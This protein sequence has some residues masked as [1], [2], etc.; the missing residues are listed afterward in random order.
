VTH[1]DSVD[2]LAEFAGPSW[3]EAVVEPG[4]EHMLAEVSCDHYET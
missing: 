2:A 4:E 1:W 3:R